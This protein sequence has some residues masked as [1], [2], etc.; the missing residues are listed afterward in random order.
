VGRGA[1]SSVL[2]VLQTVTAVSGVPVR[3]EIVGRRPGDPV[4]V[5]G[6]VDRIARE[7]GWTAKRDLLDMVRSA[8]YADRGG[9]RP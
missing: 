5:V 2:E 9:L 6:R 7:L 3:Y 4:R 8:W 1:G